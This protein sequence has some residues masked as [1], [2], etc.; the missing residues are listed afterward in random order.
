MGSN[1]FTIARYISTQAI[2][3]MTSTRQSLE[4]SAKPACC[5]YKYAVLL[6]EWKGTR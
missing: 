4:I 2:T 5:G 6:H 1:F 3:I